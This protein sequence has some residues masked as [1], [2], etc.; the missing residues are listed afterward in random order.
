M[1]SLR[2]S[3]KANDCVMPQEPRE[4]S[5]IEVAGFQSERLTVAEK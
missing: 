4:L 3:E 2:V 5:G 1:S